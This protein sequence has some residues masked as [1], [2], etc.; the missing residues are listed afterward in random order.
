MFGRKKNKTE[1]KSVFVAKQ[2]EDTEGF[3]TERLGIK[4]IIAA[5]GI[6]R[7]R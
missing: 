4:E 3:S 6:N 5:N 1:Q 2:K 7:I